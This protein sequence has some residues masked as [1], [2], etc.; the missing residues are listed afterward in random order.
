[1]PKTVDFSDFQS[2]SVVFRLKRWAAFCICSTARFSLDW[3]F[4]GSGFQGLAL[5]C[6]TSFKARK[7]KKPGGP[8]LTA[9]RHP[10]LAA[11]LVVW[12][13]GRVGGWLASV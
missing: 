8:L 1:M 3:P 11:M 9:S 12:V 2:F 13:G 6:V 4:R 5:N 10:S 7:R